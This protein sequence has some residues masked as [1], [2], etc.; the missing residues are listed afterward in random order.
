[1]CLYCSL[2]LPPYQSDHPEKCYNHK[3]DPNTGGDD[4]SVIHCLLPFYHS[5]Y[6]SDSSQPVC[7]CRP[8]TSNFSFNFNCCNLIICLVE[9]LNLIAITQAAWYTITLLVW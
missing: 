1:M 7:R 4:C 6:R 9:G 3:D 2:R 8:A 5:L